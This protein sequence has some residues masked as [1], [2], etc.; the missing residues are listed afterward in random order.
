ME[1]SRF[2]FIKLFDNDR[3]FFLNFAVLVAMLS[4][5]LYRVGIFSSGF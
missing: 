2:A 3:V 1:I 4:D 5:F